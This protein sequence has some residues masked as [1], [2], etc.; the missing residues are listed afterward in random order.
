[1]TPVYRHPPWHFFVHTFGFA[2]VY[3]AFALMLLASLTFA[4]PTSGLASIPFRIAA[5][6]G[7][8]SYGIY[9][10]HMAVKDWGSMYLHRIFG[11]NFSPRQELL[12]YLLGSIAL[13]IVFS[14]IIEVP[15]LALRDWLFPSKSRPVEPSIGSTDDLP[16]SPP[17]LAQ[18]AP[19]QAN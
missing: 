14:M 8:Y 10:W 18:V 13:G 1:M 17:I 2:F 5:F 6:C 15:F 9:L 11:W 7:T 19:T 3:V 4:I 12:I 16:S